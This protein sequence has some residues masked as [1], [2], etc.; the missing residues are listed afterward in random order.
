MQPGLG[1]NVFHG[2][3]PL[4]D[5]LFDVSCHFQAQ[6]FSE[7]LAGFGRYQVVQVGRGKVRHSL[8]Q[9]FCP[10]SARFA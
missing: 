9:E 1:R 7:A 2:A 5:F 10:I 6:I 4:S 3:Q 8:L